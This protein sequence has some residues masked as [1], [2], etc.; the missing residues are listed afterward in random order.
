MLNLA[1]NK[2]DGNLPTSLGMLSQLIDL[3]LHSNQ[4][5]GNIP[6]ELGQLSQLNIL[7]LS[8]NKL[9][10][11]IPTELGNLS[12]LK[13][14]LLN[15]NSLSGNIPPE[16]G[17]L[18][19]LTHL[20]LY[21]NQL[22]GTIPGQ[23]GM[24]S[25]LVVFYLYNNELTGNIPAEIGQLN[26]LSYLYLNHNKLSG[27]IPPELGQLNRLYYL[28]L[29]NNALQGAIPSELGQMA[30][31]R[32]MYLQANQLSDSIPASLGQLKL[33]NN[34]D[35]SINQLTG[36]IPP[37]LGNLSNL[38]VL[39]LSMN[40]LTGTLPSELG[41]LSNL[42][43]LLLERNL[44]SGVVPLGFNNF[45]KLEVLSLASN[46]LSGFA[47]DKLHQIAS[48]T[49]ISVYYNMLTF[50]DLEDKTAL[51]DRNFY[52]SPQ[53]NIGQRL[54]LQVD[55]GVN[56]TLNVDCGGS[57]NTYQWYF[58]GEALTQPSAQASHRL[59]NI[60]ESQ[61]GIYQ[62]YISSPLVPNL[63]IKSE[64]ISIQFKSSGV[65]P[66]T[67][68][69]L[70]NQ[71]IDEYSPLGTEIGKF[72][73]IDDDLNDWHTYELVEGEGDTGNIDF[74]I[75]AN[76]LHANK[77]FDFFQQNVYQIRVRTT[78]NSG[79]TLE[80]NFTIHINE[81]ASLAPTD[82]ELSNTGIDELKPAGTIVGRFSSFIDNE[83]SLQ[84]FV[85]SLVEDNTHP[86]NKYFFIASDQLFTTQTFSYDEHQG[87]KIKAQTTNP[88]N[89]SFVKTFSINVRPI[90]TLPPSDILLSNNS[91]DEN[92]PM[93]S[94][95]GIFTTVGDERINELEY[96]YTL[97]AD[98]AENN[99]F[100]I[101]HNQLHTSRV[102]FYR[103]QNSYPIVVESDDG[104][105]NTLIK[106][107]TI[108]VSK[109]ESG[110]EFFVPDA[111]SPN[112][113]GVND[114]FVIPGIEF[115]PNTY[116]AVYNRQGQ[117]VFQHE[118]YGTIP[119]QHGNLWWDGRLNALNKSSNSILPQSYYFIVLRYNTDKE[120]KKSIYLKK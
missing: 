4:F 90:E 58:N 38:L 97:F 91:I 27:N 66:P 34:L 5:S 19:N 93:G 26:S 120:I 109:N 17:N 24:L 73:T 62:C 115:Y 29:N 67:D 13:M 87:F 54:Y 21:Y 16:L 25:K 12:N 57:A 1:G 78:D 28:Q 64:P 56:Y 60:N 110:D 71:H 45:S 55:T 116:M 8:S 18:Q 114:Y 68:I 98:S 92:M 3:Y 77:V 51:F 101:A 106:S 103:E 80:K 65:Y 15:N 40:Q 52:Y 102:F 76:Q 2:L 81:V 100:F 43:Q 108:T 32:N 10:G 47:A 48:L 50:E 117:L 49:D 42:T 22:S 112:N 46:Q 119:D 85:Y 88:L 6:H 31:L 118:N 99:N 44:I 84:D 36:S 79:N 30:N 105:G 94:L 33:L 86:D 39:N 96:N 95:I 113:D 59:T 63:I 53:N 23:L 89:E 74:F 14:L 37:V 107:F 7:Y 69:M 104:R 41:Q 70:S 9:N 72:N 35:L 20:Y 75:A 82:L 61:L 111:F 83:E 11:N